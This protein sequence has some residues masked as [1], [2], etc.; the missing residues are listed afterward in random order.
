MI[1][2]R[3]PAKT[4]R[5]GLKQGYENARKEVQKLFEKN[6]VYEINGKVNKNKEKS[7]EKFKNFLKK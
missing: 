5:D 1:N 4:Y 7:L 6:L 3:K 2:E